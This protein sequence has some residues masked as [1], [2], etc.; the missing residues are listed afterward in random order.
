MNMFLINEFIHSCLGYYWVDKFSHAASSQSKTQRR[1]LQPHPLYLKARR[2]FQPSKPRLICLLFV[3]IRL[4]VNCNTTAT[5][6][7]VMQT[8]LQD[9]AISYTVAC[10]YQHRFPNRSI[11]DVYFQLLPTTPLPVSM[12]GPAWSGSRQPQVSSSCVI[13]R[14]VETR[15]QWMFCE[16][17]VNV[18]RLCLVIAM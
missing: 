9:L 15:C 11:Q 8:Y 17:T 6:H 1:P 7:W 10:C 14:L 13:L 2:G 4:D 18:Y 16:G 12:G 5:P 3:W